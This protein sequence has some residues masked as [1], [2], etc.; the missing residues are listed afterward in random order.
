MGGFF[1]GGVFYDFIGGG[2]VDGG[3]GGVEFFQGFDA[4]F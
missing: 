3:A 2:G 1:D 4:A